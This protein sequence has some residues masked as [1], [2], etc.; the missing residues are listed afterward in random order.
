MAVKLKHEASLYGTEVP[1][2]IPTCVDSRRHCVGSLPYLP[3]SLYIVWHI[4]GRGISKAILSMSLTE[5]QTA[6][7]GDMH[8]ID[9]KPLAARIVERLAAYCH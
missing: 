2:A 3:V 9:L 1:Y 6:G 8:A 5:C 4:L 7:G